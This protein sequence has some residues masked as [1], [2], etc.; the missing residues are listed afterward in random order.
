MHKISDK[1]KKIWNFLHNKFKT[2]KKEKKK[3]YNFK[4]IST[5]SKIFKTKYYFE[6]DI[7]T[8]KN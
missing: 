1:D 3:K 4:N 5:I 7:K 2:I 6:L 8:K